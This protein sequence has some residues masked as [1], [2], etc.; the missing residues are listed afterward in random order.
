MRPIS[1]PQ[2]A[3]S[4]ASSQWFKRRPRRDHSGD[5]ARGNSNA[6]GKDSVQD[7]VN[8]NDRDKGNGPGKGNSND[9]DKGSDP[10]KD[11]GL[12]GWTE[13]VVVGRA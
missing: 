2:R 11:N 4:I 13:K 10:G 8:S 12:G 1:R 5:P 6:P 7:R 3:F 9:P